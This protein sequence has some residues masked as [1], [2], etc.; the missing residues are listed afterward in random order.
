[1]EHKYVGWLPLDTCTGDT[2]R[3]MQE[4]KDDKVFMLHLFIYF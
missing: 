4:T 3:G 1:M 2:D